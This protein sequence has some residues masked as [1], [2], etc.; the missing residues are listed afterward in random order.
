[1]H[2]LLRVHVRAPVTPCTYI[3]ICDPYE[4]S[5]KNA[6]EDECGSNGRRGCRI[7]GL[8]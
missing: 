2:I 8:G 4:K 6:A 7:K 1:M 5:H 3:C